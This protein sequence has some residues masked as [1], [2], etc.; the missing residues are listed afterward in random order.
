[1]KRWLLDTNSFETTL[2]DSHM[3]LPIDNRYNI[4][5]LKS[6]IELK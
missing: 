6:I 4:N 1:V 5:Y 3:C 2:I